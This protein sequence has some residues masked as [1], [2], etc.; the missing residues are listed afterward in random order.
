MKPVIQVTNLSKSFKVFNKEAGLKGSI[1]AVFKREH[2]IFKAVDDISFT[3]GEGEIVGFLGP[4]GA[5]KTT[6]LKM[7]SGLLKPTLGEVSVI[8]Y[9]PF[10]RK[11]AFLKSISLV[12]GQKNQLWWDIPAIETFRLNKEIYDVSDKD[13]EKRFKEMVSLL[14]VEKVLYKQARK[15]S[16]GER[17][18]CEIIAAL[19]H[20]PKVLFLDEPTI[21]LDI[22]MQKKLR[23]FIL[24]YNRRHNATIVLTSH[25]MDDV[26]EVCQRIILVNKGKLLFDGAISELNKR[27]GDYKLITIYTNSVIDKAKLATIGEVIKF[28]ELKATIKT[29]SMNIPAK[30][31]ELL[32]SFDVDDIDIH[33]PKLEEII[34]ELGY[35]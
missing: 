7:L 16:L 3:I 13:Y 32:K 24:E 19:I 30:V 10:Q 15:L 22:T 12:M 31:T 11:E 33:E 28:D 35:I 25:N 1:K 21:G 27:A 8:G 17:M 2:K 5:G 34:M 23:A 14:D 26:K 4:N 9:D 29:S 6:T 18:K 20:E